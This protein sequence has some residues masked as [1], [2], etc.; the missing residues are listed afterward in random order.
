MM[1]NSLKTTEQTY[2]NISFLIN[3]FEKEKD[4]LI[5]VF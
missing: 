2:K 4:E 1:C 3:N 5:K